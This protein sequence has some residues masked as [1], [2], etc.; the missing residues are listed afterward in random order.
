MAPR[1]THTV[2]IILARLC[3]TQLPLFIENALRMT[4]RDEKR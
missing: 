2:R 4:D 3:P 1:E